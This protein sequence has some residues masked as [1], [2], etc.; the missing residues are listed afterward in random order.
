MER[1]RDESSSKANK[2][3]SGRGRP[4]SQTARTAVLGA[5]YQ[6]AASQ[7]GQGTTIEAIAK[8]S[9]VSKMTI[10]KWWPDRQTLLTDAFLWQIGLEVPLSESGDA[11]QSIH[12]HAARYVSL[13]GGDMGRVLKV[14]L[15]ECLTRSGDTATFFDRYLKER[16]EL[17][18]RVISSGQR[19]GAIRSK[20]EPFD[21][22][23]RIYGTIFYRFIFGMPDLNP[24]FVR[25]LVDDVLDR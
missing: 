13:L 4:R 7:G 3:S 25:Q 21:V 14:V 8:S 20:S 2:H 10:Y 5:A 19:S 12:Q 6:L 23:D 16:R 24:A 18:A 11:A 1:Q 9:G 17:G 22:Y 15:S